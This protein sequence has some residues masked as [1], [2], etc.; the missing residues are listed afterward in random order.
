[1]LRFVCRLLLLSFATSL[2]S[3]CKSRNQPDST[4]LFDLVQN[5]GID[6]NNK[7]EDGRLDNS[8]LF[9]NFYNGGGVAIRSEERR[10]GKE[11]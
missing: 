7:V 2:F 11:C 4:P 9:R 6:F 8:F 5:T 1:M 10:V 3:Q